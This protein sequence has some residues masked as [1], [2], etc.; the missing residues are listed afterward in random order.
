MPHFKGISRNGLSQ[1]DWVNQETGEVIEADP[2]RY[3]VMQCF[4]EAKQEKNISKH[5]LR[6]YRQSLRKL[7]GFIGLKFGENSGLVYDQLTRAHIVEFLTFL[8]ETCDNGAASRHHILIGA[9]QLLRYAL[10]DLMSGPFPAFIRDVTVK[11][12]V[13]DPTKHRISEEEF[14][15]ILEASAS[16]PWFQTYIAL[17]YDTGCRR[18]EARNCKVKDFSTDERGALLR[19]SG[20]TGERTVRLAFST[21]HVIEHVN[22]LPNDKEGW[23]F[24]SPIRPKARICNNSVSGRFTVIRKKLGYKKNA[25]GRWDLNLHTFRHNRATIVAEKGWNEQLMREHFGWSKGSEMPSH[26]T[27]VNRGALDAA[28]FKSQGMGELIVQEED[29]FGIETMWDCRMCSEFNPMHHNFC[30]KCG[31]ARSRGVAMTYDNIIETIEK[32]VAGQMAEKAL[33]EILA[34]KELQE[35]G[36]ALQP[37]EALKEELG[38]S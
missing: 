23:L 2:Q 37:D 16:C 28:I 8:R 32:K 1:L 7:E 29:D 17:L 5:T 27:H 13:S 18:G 35:L 4:L 20:K 31:Q 34:D 21:R 22:R 11:I 10:T 30:G 6:N 12:N 24:P 3:V 26:Y 25:K 19:L 38:L 9:K 33:N 15:Q 36:N 14:K